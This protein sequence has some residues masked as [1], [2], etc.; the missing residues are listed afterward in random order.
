LVF[1][2][3]GLEIKYLGATKKDSSSEFQKKKLEK[4]QLDRNN[5]DDEKLKKQIQTTR[6]NSK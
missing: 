2:N 1:S 6:Y 5:N 4:E 3:E